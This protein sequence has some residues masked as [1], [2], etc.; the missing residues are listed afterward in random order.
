MTWR[1]SHMHG[2]GDILSGPLAEYIL[3][4]DIMMNNKAAMAVL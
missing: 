4:L 2:F 1:W 3:K